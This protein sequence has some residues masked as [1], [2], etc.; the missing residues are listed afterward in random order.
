M[1][2]TT[3]EPLRAIEGGRVSILGSNFPVDQP[4][5]PE[6]RIGELRARVVYAS[7]TRITALVPTGIAE[8]GRAAVRIDGSADDGAFVEVGTPF[9]TGLHQV[10][11]PVFDRDGN[12]YVTYSGTRGLQV[13]VSIFRVRPNGT[14]ETFSSGI[15]NPT[16]IAV[17]RREPRLRVEPLRGHRLPLDGGG[18]GAAVCHR[19]RR[20]LRPR[21]RAGRDAVCRRSIGDDLQGR[22]RQARRKPF[23]TLPPSVAA[24]H[25]ALAPGRRALR[26]RSDA[27][28]V[29]RGLSRR[30]WRRRH[31]SGARRSGGRR[32]WRSI[33]RARCSSWRRLPARAASIACRQTA[34]PSSCSPRRVSSVSPSIRDGGLVVCSNDSAY[35]LPAS[36]WSEH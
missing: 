5:L 3:V 6:V 7:P 22:S 19:P 29:R 14:R 10:D 4:Q 15:V 21:V 32:D 18:R 8:S 34:S 30:R 20:G 23:A 16:S 11:S 25:L 27:F 26:H 1:T 35:K 9:A 36:S 33:R 12:L 31:A 28:T 24:F 2:V 17:D 13:P